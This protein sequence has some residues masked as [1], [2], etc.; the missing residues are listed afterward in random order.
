MPQQGGAT[1]WLVAGPPV[2]PVWD[3]LR[4]DG[5]AS[6]ASR[7]AGG[8]AGSEP[9][10]S[11]GGGRAVGPQRD[12]P[13]TGGMAV[14]AWRGLIVRGGVRDTAHPVDGGPEGKG[15]LC[16][17]QRLAVGYDDRPATE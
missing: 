2:W 10:V 6:G 8:Q 5:T 1:K 4:A 16:A 11:P 17:R 13:D 14:E 3:D 15:P 12:L 7:A 9:G